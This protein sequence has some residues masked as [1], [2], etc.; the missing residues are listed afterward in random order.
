MTKRELINA[1]EASGHDD[2][3]PVEVVLDGEIHFTIE[4]ASWWEIKAAEPWKE[5]DGTITKDAPILLYLGELM[6]G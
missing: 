5:S 6:M 1:L 2:S 4:D 3:A